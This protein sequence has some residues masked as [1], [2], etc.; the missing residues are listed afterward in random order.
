MKIP[1]NNDPVFILWNKKK[2]IC[3]N[4][5]IYFTTFHHEFLFL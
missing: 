3:Y 2:I 5:A 1:F 4:F